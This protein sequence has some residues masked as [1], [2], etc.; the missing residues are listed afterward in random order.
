MSDFSFDDLFKTN[1][2]RPEHPDFWKLSSIVLDLDASMTEGVQR[3]EQP[4]EVLARK[5][6]EVG[7]SYSFAYM[8][9]Q[10]AFRVHGVQTVGDLMQ[11]MPEVIKTATIYMEA[12]I[13]GARF[14]EE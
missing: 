8:A 7:D 11:N 6:G 5:M 12:M 3:G 14:H 10:R 2:P 1:L 9:T 4:D 13:V